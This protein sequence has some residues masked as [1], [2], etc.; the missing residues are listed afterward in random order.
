MN[1]SQGR[2]LI[3]LLLTISGTVL[4]Q[5]ANWQFIQEHGGCAVGEFTAQ[6]GATAAGQSL[7]WDLVIGATA[8]VMAMIVE[9]RRLQMRHLQWPVLASM[10]IAFAAGA[11]LFLLMRERHLQQLEDANG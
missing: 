3:Y 9:G 2:Q 6:A 4:T 1:G 5:R 8:G 10:L 7:S 11:P